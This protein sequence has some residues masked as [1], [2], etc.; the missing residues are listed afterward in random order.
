[1]G[2]RRSS[3]RRLWGGQVALRRF[4]TL[5]HGVKLQ[6][7]SKPLKLIFICRHYQRWV[8]GNSF[9]DQLKELLFWVRHFRE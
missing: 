6:Q 9:V 4:T 7:I 2:H 8:V 1:L 3:N 5:P